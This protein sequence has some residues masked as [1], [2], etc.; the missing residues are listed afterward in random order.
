MNS[1]QISNL[2]HFIITKWDFYVQNLNVTH[3]SVSFSDHES[4]V[5]N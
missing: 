5:V 1:L 3:T 2:I 4:Y